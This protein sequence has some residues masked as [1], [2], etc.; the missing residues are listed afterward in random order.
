MFRVTAAQL[1]PYFKISATPE[2][3]NVLCQLHGLEA[4]RQQFHE[5]RTSSI[6]NTRRCGHAETFLQT[7]AHNGSLCSL[8]VVDKYAA[9]RRYRYV[10]W[11]QTVYLLLLVIGYDV[12]NDLSKVEFF[13]F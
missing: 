9:A 4:W 11:C 12:P 5:Y 13:Q 10:C 6:V 3:L 2:A 8:T 7:H 1:F